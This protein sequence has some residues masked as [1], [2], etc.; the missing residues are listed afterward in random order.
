MITNGVAERVHLPEGVIEVAEE[1]IYLGQIISFKNKLEKE[2]Q[3]RIRAVQHG[4]NFGP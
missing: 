1:V 3:R 2:I 4:K